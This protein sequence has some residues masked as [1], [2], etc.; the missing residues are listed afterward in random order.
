MLCVSSEREFALSLEYVWLTCSLTF[1]GNSETRWLSCGVRVLSQSPPPPLHVSYLGWLEK[2]PVKSEHTQ[3]W[4][5]TKM[6]THKTSGSPRSGKWAFIRF[7]SF[8]TPGKKSS[9]GAELNWCLRWKKNS[10]WSWRKSIC[11]QYG[12]FV[13]KKRDVLSLWPKSHAVVNVKPGLI[14]R[15]L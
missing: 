9:S 4:A 2:R 3:K 1:W 12:C 13:S 10:S 15:R 8:R 7:Q 11:S 14:Y 5:H 6:N